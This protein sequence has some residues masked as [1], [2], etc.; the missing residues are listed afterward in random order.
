MLARNT[1]ISGL[2]LPARRLFSTST[3]RMATQTNTSSN[4]PVEDAI[5]EKV[6]YH[7]A[8]TKS[9]PFT[10]LFCVV[11]KLMVCLLS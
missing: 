6:P 8:A 4:T 10:V 1:R 5:R 7:R 3:F 2:L 11:A 9:I